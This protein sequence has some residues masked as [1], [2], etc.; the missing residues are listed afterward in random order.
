MNTLNFKQQMLINNKTQNEIKY[1]RVHLPHLC[2]FLITDRARTIQP[3]YINNKNKYKIK[4][5]QTLK[6][7]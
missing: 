3:I 4:I 7:F 2:A 6:I 1:L 5:I